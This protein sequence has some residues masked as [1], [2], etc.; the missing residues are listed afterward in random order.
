MTKASVFGKKDYQS[1]TTDKILADSGSKFTA[2]VF[3]YMLIALAITAVTTMAFS[4]ILTSIFANGTEEQI[5]TLVTVGVVMLICYIP[6]I[7]W[8]QIAVLRGGKGLTPAFVIYSIFMGALLSPIVAIFQS[9][10]LAGFADIAGFSLMGTV[11]IAFGLTCAVFGIMSLIAWTTK[12]NLSGLAIAGY[13]L[14][15]GIGFVFLIYLIVTLISGQEAAILSSIISGGFFIFVILIT[16]VDLYNIR[17]IAAR[18]ETSSNLAMVC[19][20]SLYTDFVYIFI[21]ILGFVIRIAA[22]FGGSKR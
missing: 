11:G 18:G 12:K 13:G 20:F 3:I 1:E 8:I 6:L 5:S 17:R 9:L 14:L 22:L 15:S 7:I 4:W 19:A 10:D 2:K 16:M 21:R